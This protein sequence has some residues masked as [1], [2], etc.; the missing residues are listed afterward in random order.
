MENQWKIWTYIIIENNSRWMQMLLAFMD[1]AYTGSTTG[2]WGADSESVDSSTMA[3]ADPLFL[4]L[5]KEENDGLAIR[6]PS[7]CNFYITFWSI[8]CTWIDAT[9][10]LSGIWTDL[11]SVIQPWLWPCCGSR[12]SPKEKKM[13]WIPNFDIPQMLWECYHMQWSIVP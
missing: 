10:D 11:N 8:Q 2:D 4:E 12:I 7:C 6:W 13:P 9:F 3:V 5:F 1:E